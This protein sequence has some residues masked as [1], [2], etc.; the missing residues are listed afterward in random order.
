MEIVGCDWA[1]A[2]ITPVERIMSPA[3]SWRRNSTRCGRDPQFGR[4][5]PGARRISR[6]SNRIQSLR[7]HS[8]TFFRNIVRKIRG[9]VRPNPLAFAAH[10][11]IVKGTGKAPLPPLSAMKRLRAGILFVAALAPVALAQQ[12]AATPSINI[13][14]EKYAL[15]N[16]LTVLLGEDHA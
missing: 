9:A 15:S 1:I 2:R 12:P 3:R 11:S 8:S 13:P 14:F 6:T 5:S 7:H 16:G 4:P 10:S